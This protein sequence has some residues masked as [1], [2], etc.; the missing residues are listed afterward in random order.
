MKCVCH[1]IRSMFGVL[2]LYNFAPEF[3][4]E[5]WFQDL[6]KLMPC[7]HY[8]LYLLLLWVLADIS[9]LE[10]KVM[11]S[12][13]HSYLKQLCLFSRQESLSSLRF[14]T[15]CTLLLIL[16]FLTKTF[17]TTIAQS[18]AA[19]H[20]SALRAEFYCKFYNLKVECIVHLRKCAKCKQ[21]NS[22]IFA[23]LSTAE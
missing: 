10:L 3:N 11:K 8:V 5:F 19:Q 6:M 4:F 16:S 9:C 17:F 12:F 2:G 7:H 22:Q 20:Y 18:S 13:Q 14:F 23:L 1:S 15:I 21:T